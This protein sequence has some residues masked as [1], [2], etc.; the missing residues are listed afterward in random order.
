VL[1]RFREVAG[2][3]SPHAFLDAIEGAI[4]KA[5]GVGELAEAVGLLI[6][7]REAVAQGRTLGELMDHLELEYSRHRRKDTWKAIRERTRVAVEE[8]PDLPVESI[9]AEEIEAW[10]SRGE[11]GARTYNNR[12]ETWKTVLRRARDLGWLP[13][14]ELVAAELVKRKR[15]DR[16]SPEIWT[17]REAEKALAFLATSTT[18][19]KHIPWFAV[20]AWAGLRPSEARELKRSDIDLKGGYIHVRAAVATKL[21]QERF[22]PIQPNLRAILERFW[23]Q[24]GVKFALKDPAKSVS[25]ILRTGGILEEWKQDALRHSFCSYRLAVTKTIGLVAEEAGNSEAIIR[26]NY[27]RPVPKEAG[28]GWFRIGL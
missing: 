21:G 14:Q 17:I 26:T 20:C 13:R 6:S 24:K 11:I 23:P 4:R 10:A 27:R 15:Q 19:R 16:K 28:E 22:V 2:S 25:K 8:C 18:S 3:S 1:E 5:G 12:L 7:K 9:G